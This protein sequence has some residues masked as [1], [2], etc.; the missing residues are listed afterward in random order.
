MS[1]I[2]NDLACWARKSAAMGHGTIEID[3]ELATQASEEIVAQANRI[4]SLEAEVRYLQNLVSDMHDILGRQR[5]LL[6][7]HIR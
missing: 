5:A 3:N 1:S 2:H 7:G 4:G 6:S